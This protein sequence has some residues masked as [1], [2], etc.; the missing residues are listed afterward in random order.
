VLHHC[1]T[2]TDSLP[3]ATYL[4]FLVTLLAKWPS[5]S[6]PNGAGSGANQSEPREDGTPQ[7]GRDGDLGVTTSSGEQE[8]AGGKD[9]D[10]ILDAVC[11][12]LARAGGGAVMLGLVGPLLTR[13]L[14]TATGG[15]PEQQGAVNVAAAYAAL[16]AISTCVETGRSEEKTDAAL[17]PAD[18]AA[19]MPSALAG[20]W[21]ELTSSQGSR[22]VAPGEARSS[23]WV[24]QRLRPCLLLLQRQ[25]WLLVPMLG[26]VGRYSDAHNGAPTSSLEQQSQAAS[27]GKV[28]LDFLSK[29]CGLEEVH[30][31]LV[32]CRGAIE[33]LVESLQIIAKGAE[34]PGVGHRGL[35]LHEDLARL[36]ARTAVLFGQRT[37]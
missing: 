22:N 7:G 35:L 6:Q 11:A 28:V 13:L 34:G 17:F 5:F 2:A 20:Y 36:E 30:A 15:Q 1:A 21:L 31:L 9:S 18:L 25:P 24:T 14:Q 26:C 3:L 27:R 4:S 16:R 8:K 33:K 29:L 19:L 32:D 10:V 23:A 37:P 12:G